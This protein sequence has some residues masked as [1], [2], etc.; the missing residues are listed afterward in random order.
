MFLIG[1]TSV[2]AISSIPDRVPDLYELY[3]QVRIHR[4]MY[5]HTYKGMDRRMGDGEGMGRGILGFVQNISSLLPSLPTSGLC[6]G[7]ALICVK[8]LKPTFI[9]HFEQAEIAQS[10]V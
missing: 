1:V 4:Y 8:S 10:S 3:T 2:E 5:I 7:D 6:N 9:L